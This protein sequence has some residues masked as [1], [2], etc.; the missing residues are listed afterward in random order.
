MPTGASTAGHPGW[1][2][3]MAARLSASLVMVE[4]GACRSAEAFEF[5]NV[6]A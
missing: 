6:I 2:W 4:A 1:V 3:C 5:P